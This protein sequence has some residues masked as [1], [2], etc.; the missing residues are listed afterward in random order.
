MQLI[1]NM[2]YMSQGF[3][4]A[5][6]AGLSQHVHNFGLTWSSILKFHKI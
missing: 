1:Y 4:Q 2:H 5:M 6:L 3:D